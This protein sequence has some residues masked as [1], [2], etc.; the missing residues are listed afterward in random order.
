MEASPS[1]P[2][3]VTASPGCDFGALRDVDR[4]QI[5]RYGPKDWREFAAD[6]YPAAIRQPVWHAVSISHGKHRDSH[7]LRRVKD[8]T[9]S[10]LCPAGISLTV[11]TAAF[12]HIAGFTFKPLTGPDLA[13]E[14]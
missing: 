11:R 6:N 13:G 1:E 10:N 14:T 9:V 8:A 12:Q 5:H 7:R 2:R 4:R 3:I